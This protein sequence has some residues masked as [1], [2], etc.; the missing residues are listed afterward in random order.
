LICNDRK[1][2]KLGIESDQIMDKMVFNGVV[3]LIEPKTIGNTV[4]HG[5]FSAF[6]ANGWAIFD[7][8]VS[9]S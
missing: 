6:L 1:K 9:D 4:K 3:A 8:R 2:Q 5:F 7:S